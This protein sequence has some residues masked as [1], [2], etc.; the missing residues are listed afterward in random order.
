LETQPLFLTG[1][2][3][4]SQRRLLGV[5]DFAPFLGPFLGTTHFY[6]YRESNRGASRLLD[7]LE[8]PLKK[9]HRREPKLVLRIYIACIDKPRSTGTR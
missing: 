9:P 7:F 6:F 4:K 8:K 2:E 1:R 5:P 3:D